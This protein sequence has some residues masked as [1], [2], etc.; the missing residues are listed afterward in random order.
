[1]SFFA[2]FFDFFVKQQVLMYFVILRE[3]VHILIAV[4]VN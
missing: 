2:V 4:T 1:L 3:V